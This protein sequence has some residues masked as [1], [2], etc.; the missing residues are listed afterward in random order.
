M[1]TATNTTAEKLSDMLREN[2]GRSILDSGGAYGR[3]WERNQAVE[4]FD[5]QPE[6]KLEFWI[7]KDGTPDIVPTLNVYHF[8][9]ERLE[10]NED[11]DNRYREFVEREDLY[12]DLDSAE[13]FVNSLDGAKGIYGDGKPF[14]ENTYNGEDM[15]SQCIQYVYW[16]DDD[17]AHVMLQ[18][19]NGC[20]VRGGYTDPVVFDV[21]DY[22]GTSIFDN[23]QATIYCNDCHKTWDTESGYSW[24]Q[25]DCWGKC[26]GDC[27]RDL[28][29][30]PAT[31]K[32]PAYPEPPH[33]DQLTLP[34]DLPERPDPC[35][36]VLWI[37]EDGNG[38][39]PYCGGLLKLAPWPCG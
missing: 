19:H 35:S 17:G 31:D 13:R 18:I 10:Y 4:S 6:G 23:A 3:H 37:D 36:G 12:L 39:C 26:F 11:L 29:E 27:H 2:T 28:R 15:L 16:T 7:H 14:T 21:T 20:D 32:R 24:I 22:D 33:P 5:E 38:H 1:I 9:L 34:I 30:Y 25:S 8:L